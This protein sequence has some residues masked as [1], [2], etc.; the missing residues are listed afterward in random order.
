M[1]KL[2]QR[3]EKKLCPHVGTLDGDNVRADTTT[4][5]TETNVCVLG[6]FMR[7]SLARVNI[8]ASSFIHSPH[9]HHGARIWP[10]I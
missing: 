6:G 9:F 2:R 8:R 3:P 7:E 5:K 10:T 4:T 1:N